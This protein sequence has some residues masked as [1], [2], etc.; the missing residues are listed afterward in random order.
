M[1]NMFEYLGEGTHLKPSEIKFTGL[2]Y[3]TGKI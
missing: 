2:Q 3:E 1:R